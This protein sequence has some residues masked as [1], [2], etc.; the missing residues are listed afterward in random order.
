MVNS[1]VNCLTTQNGLHQLC[2]VGCLCYYSL[3]YVMLCFYLILSLILVKLPTS[4]SK[5]LIHHSFPCDYVGIQP[6]V[7][8]TD[9]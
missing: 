8:T 6:T 2:R 1:K 4:L 3:H 9:K 5:K 7:E